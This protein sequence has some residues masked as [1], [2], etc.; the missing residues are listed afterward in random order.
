M[1]LVDKDAV[2]LREGLDVL[3]VALNP[4][5][6]SNNNGHYFSGR[7]SRFFQQLFKSGLITENLDKLIAD[8]LVFGG[9]K[10]NYKNKLFGVIDLKPRTEETNSNRVKVKREDVM[11]M[12]DRIRRYRPKIVCIIHSEVKNQF[13]KVTGISLQDGFNGKVLDGCDTDFYYNHFPNGNSIPDEVKIDIYRT[14]RNNL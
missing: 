12:L 9:T 8:E 11:L 5:Q 6:Q 1:K 13:G 14:I 4:P 3:F 2:Y 7:N 10:Y